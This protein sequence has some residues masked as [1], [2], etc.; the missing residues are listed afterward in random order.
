MRD[1]GVEEWAGI[2]AGRRLRCLKRVERLGVPPRG[3]E[4]NAELKLS[5]RVAGVELDGPA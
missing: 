3:L 5:V 4:R 2:V 1:G